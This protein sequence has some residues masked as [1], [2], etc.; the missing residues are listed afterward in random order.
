MNYKNL[1]IEKIFHAAVKI[2]GP[3][4]IYL[5]PFTL[6]KN[7]EPADL[8]FITHEHHDHLSL[9]D[10]KKITT[11]NTTIVA[12]PMC[13]EVLKNLEIAK[14]IYVKPGDNL[15][16]KNIKVEIVPA[17]NTNKFRSPGIPFHPSE[18]GKVGYVLEIEGV[19]I[20]Q[21]GDTDNIPE[22]ANLKNI[23][24][25]LL[26]ISGIFVMTPEEAAEAAN[27]IKPKIAIPI[28]YGDYEFNGNVLGPKE[29]AEIFKKLCQ[30]PV[31]II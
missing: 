12:T 26:P 19:R 23:D 6:P 9:E 28:H 2:K 1:T 8:I 18:H 31:E 15:E 5:D 30:V 7:S 17:Y 25:A 21:A 10:L 27:T 20:Y 13:E 16:I 29:N 4:V 24:L 11:P 22:M 3:Q 14:I